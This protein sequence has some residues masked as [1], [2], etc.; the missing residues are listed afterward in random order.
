M[1]S[2]EPLEDNNSTFKP[3]KLKRLDTPPRSE[4]RGRYEA[5]PSEY[6]GRYEAEM[7][8]DSTQPFAL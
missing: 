1:N 7:D 2:R 3:K 6:H 8:T 5:E 4:Y